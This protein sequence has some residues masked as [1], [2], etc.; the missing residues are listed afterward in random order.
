MWQLI[1]LNFSKKKH[2][3]SYGYEIYF[4]TIKGT[5]SKMYKNHPKMSQTERNQND[6]FL[7]CLANMKVIESSVQNIMG[8]LWVSLD[9]EGF[10]PK[11]GL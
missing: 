10:I 8:I 1:L 6:I 11:M 2:K 9:K 7:F 5:C 3:N 4:A